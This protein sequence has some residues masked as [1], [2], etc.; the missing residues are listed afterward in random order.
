MVGGHFSFNSRLLLI[1]IHW[2]ITRN[3]D[4][5]IDTFV[6]EY[7]DAIDKVLKKRGQAL[8]QTR[9]RNSRHR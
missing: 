9:W 1:G 7:F 6:P 2:S 3:P 8:R 5:S 4:S